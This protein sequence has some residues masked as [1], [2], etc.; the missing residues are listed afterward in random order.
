MIIELMRWWYT[1][2]WMHAAH[3]ISTWTLGVYHTFSV[4][5]L[6]RT[7]FAPWRRIISIPGRS[8]DARIHAAF[9]NFISRCIGC[10]VRSITLVVASGMMIAAFV[11]G[12]MLCV[13]WP[14]IPLFAA[15][16]AVRSIAG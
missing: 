10:I 1:T 9:D 14:C 13:V 11:A 12:L 15:Y 5:I 3:R 16:C 4:G 8:I 2:G 6:L 7:L